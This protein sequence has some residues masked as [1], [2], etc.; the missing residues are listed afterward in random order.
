M[1]T[2]CLLAE[3]SYF[4]LCPGDAPVLFLFRRA[5]IVLISIYVRAMPLFLRLFRYNGTI[6]ATAG[7]AS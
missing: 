4:Y 1:G 7:G 3:A 5:E 6:W 2:P